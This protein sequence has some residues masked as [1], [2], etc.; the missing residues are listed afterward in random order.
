MTDV[1]KKIMTLHFTDGRSE[2]APLEH[3]PE[4]FAFAAFGGALGRVESEV[5]NLK[6]SNSEP[7]LINC[8][9]IVD[10]RLNTTL[11]PY[12]FLLDP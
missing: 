7:F 4:G 2:T 10:H 9:P 1:N 12:Q 5:P 3:G 11:L 6:F 8:L